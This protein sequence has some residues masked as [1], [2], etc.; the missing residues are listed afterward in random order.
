MDSGAIDNFISTKIL[1]TRI[2]LSAIACNVQKDTG[3]FI[4]RNRFM[5][6]VLH[7]SMQLALPQASLG[8]SYGNILLHKH[9]LDN[10]VLFFLVHV[11]HYFNKLFSIDLSA[12]LWGWG[13]GVWELLEAGL[14]V[15]FPSS[16]PVAHALESFGFSGQF[17][18][19][20]PWHLRLFFLQ[21]G[22]FVVRVCPPEV[23]MALKSL[24]NPFHHS[25][26]V[27]HFPCPLVWN[28]L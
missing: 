26:L 6:T 27:G 8:Q 4:D 16:S 13:I 22:P 10:F 18:L 17:T 21:F 7:C 20:C 9:V 23:S 24:A 19:S 11:V 2:R 5:Y 25:C 1:S 3:I 28:R 12:S 15:V 14:K